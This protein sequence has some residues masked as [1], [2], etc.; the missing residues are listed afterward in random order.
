MANN[1]DKK[2]KNQSVNKRAI[3]A[4]IKQ[5]CKF[6]TTLRSTMVCTKDTC[7]VQ[8]FRDAL[9]SGGIEQKGKS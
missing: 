9:I 5:E 3:Q 1:N 8:I 7:C 6:H 4:S 2:K